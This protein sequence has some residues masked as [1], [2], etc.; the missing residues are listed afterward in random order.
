[1]TFETVPLS[2]Y[3]G[4]HE[5]TPGTITAAVRK[6]YFMDGELKPAVART[7]VTERR[8]S[9]I[10]HY[11]SFPT[12]INSE[13]SGATAAPTYEDFG[14]AAG[15]FLAGT[16][17]PVPTNVTAWR[18]TFKGAA[19]DDL[20]TATL[21][22]GQRSGNPFAVPGCLGNRLEMG[23]SAT[24][25]MTMSM[26]FLGGI[27][28]QQAMTSNMVDRTTEDINGSLAT[29]Y[30][31]TT[32]IGS[33]AVTNVLSAKLTIDNKWKQFFALVGTNGPSDQYREEA[34]M[35][36]LE[37]QVAF[38]DLTEYNKFISV[39]S[40]ENPRKVRIKILGSTIAGASSS[41]KKSLTLDWYGIWETAE[42]GT[43][44]G[45][46]VVNLKGR[47]EYDSTAATDWSVTVDNDVSATTVSS[48]Y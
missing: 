26:D 7:Y 45:L 4:G 47:S 11:R 18:Q 33:T 35:A 10:A 9:L 48:T 22:V 15:L 6:L 41:L 13:I 2:R 21:E 23:W 8:G 46:R 5:G 31:D 39:T 19:G 16:V 1:M 43:Q 28:V 25:P 30:I 42:F 27:P 24:Q 20:K 29:A 40:A 14:W 17:T 32:T 12:K 38:I 36:E 44:D 34:R 37:M 3:Q